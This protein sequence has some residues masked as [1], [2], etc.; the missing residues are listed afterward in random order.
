MSPL[1]RMPPRDNPSLREMHALLREMKA[2]NTPFEHREFDLYGS[3]KKA[4]NQAASWSGQG[5][6]GAARKKWDLLSAEKRKEI[7]TSVVNSMQTW[8]LTCKVDEIN[9]LKK[10]FDENPEIHAKWVDLDSKK[11]NHVSFDKQTYDQKKQVMIEVITFLQTW[12][13]KCKVGV[14]DTKVNSFKDLVYF[15]NGIDNQWIKDVEAAQV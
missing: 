10:A 7:M 5:K 14:D 6:T 8:I 3:L 15:I 12:I 1:Q 13:T 9:D 2:M 4:G 11:N